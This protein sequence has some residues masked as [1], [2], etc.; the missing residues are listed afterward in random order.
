L[1]E[2]TSHT[3]FM[4]AS[5]SANA[6]RRRH[7]DSGVTTTTGNR[8]QIWQ[9]DKPPRRAPLPAPFR[10]RETAAGPSRLQRQC[11]AA[12]QGTISFLSA[13]SK[14][15]HGCHRIRRG[16]AQSSLHRQPLLDLDRD[17]ALGPK[18]VQ[19]PLGDAIAGV[20]RIQRNPRIFIRAHDLNPASPPR[21]SLNAHPDHV[22]QRNRLVH[23]AQMVISV[24]AR[25]ADVEPEIDL[26][27]RTNAKRS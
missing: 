16:R 4:S 20:R 13:R 15:K 1:L 14:R 26:R 3:S 7:S 11:A 27:K 21:V 23:R 24:R 5:Q 22:M 19:H 12:P 18:F 6:L 17:V 10:P 8:R 25:G 9:E 2:A